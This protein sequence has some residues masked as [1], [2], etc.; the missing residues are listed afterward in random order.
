MANIWK[1]VSTD[2]TSSLKVFIFGAGTRKK[3]EEI[4]NKLDALGY[5]K[6]AE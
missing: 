4:R 2:I 6:S 5:Q 3:S 1:F